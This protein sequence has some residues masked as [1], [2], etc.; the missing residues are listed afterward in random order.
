MM[1]YALQWYAKGGLHLGGK[2]KR[3]VEPCNAPTVYGLEYLHKGA[4]RCIKQVMQTA[5]NERS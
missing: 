5:C 2:L 4:I 3:H 1:M